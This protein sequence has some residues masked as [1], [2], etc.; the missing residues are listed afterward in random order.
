MFSRRPASGYCGVSPTLEKCLDVHQ[1]G[2]AHQG[3][4]EP[5]MLLASG[6]W[7]QHETIS[8]ISWWCS[9]A[10]F[11]QRSF[12]SLTVL[13]SYIGVI[14][15]SKKAAFSNATAVMDKVNGLSEKGWAM[16]DS[17]M[18]W[19]EFGGV[20]VNPHQGCCIQW[21]KKHGRIQGARTELRDRNSQLGWQ[22]GIAEP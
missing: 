7:P 8:C 1:H 9:S 10:S 16:I 19:R 3:F 11:D 2:R 15:I 18:D 6:R 17:R 4:L 22:Q 20:L 12:V 14:I 5:R 21:S 13:T